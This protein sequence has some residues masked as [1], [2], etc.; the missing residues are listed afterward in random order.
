MAKNEDLRGKIWVNPNI[1]KEYQN[2]VGSFQQ[3]WEGYGTFI[4][5][6][7]TQEKAF[8]VSGGQSFLIDISTNQLLN[9][10]YFR[11]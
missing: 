2:G 5:N 6:I 8:I 4:I 7:D 1:D 3:G 11:N 10:K 9:N